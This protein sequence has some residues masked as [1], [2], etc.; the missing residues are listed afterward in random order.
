MIHLFPSVAGINDRL[1]R[2]Q[3]LTMSAMAG[4]S[5][6]HLAGNR[7]LLANAAES[8]QTPKSCIYIFLCGGP[9]QP[10]LWDLKPD[11]P[12]GIRSEF[13]PIQTNVPGIQF[14]ELIPQ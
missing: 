5:F 7:N 14:G 10:D 9:S 13:Q 11:A 1:T 2:R 6:M 4:G 8:R 12:S 3:W